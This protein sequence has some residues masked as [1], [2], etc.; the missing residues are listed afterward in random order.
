MAEWLK[1]GATTEAK[2][3]NDRKVRDTVEGILADIAARLR[4]IQRS[5][6]WQAQTPKSLS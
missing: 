2:A 4:G 3:D 5:K 1:R 6:F